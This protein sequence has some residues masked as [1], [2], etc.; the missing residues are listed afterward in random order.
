MPISNVTINNTFYEWLTTTNQLI[1]AVNDLNDGNVSLNFLGSN[2]IISNTGTF[3]SAISIAGVNVAPTLTAAFAQANTARSHANVSFSVGNS[4]FGHANVAYAQANTARDLGNTVFAATN[5]AFA[6]ANTGASVGSAYDQA[7]TARNS[8]NSALT[9][10]GVAFDQANTARIHA[11]SAF[12][13]ANSAYNTANNITVFPS[14]TR[15][16]FQQTSA[17]TGWTKIT[18]HNDKTLRVVS[19]TAS[20]GGS[21][22][23]ST[24]FASKTPT[25]SVTMNSVTLSE[26]NLPVVTPTV[27]YVTGVA[28]GASPGLL[29]INDGTSSGAT[30][31]NS[32]GSASPFTPTGSFSGNAM[33]FAVQYVDVILASKD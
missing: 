6:Q 24:V 19:G 23:F 11:N 14:G 27:N 28:S 12:S 9:L 29:F 18:T 4:A 25:G 33:D 1:V 10:G 21:T 26:A 31:I 7:N 3:N 5:A 32:F 16:L 8:A 15:L 22:A 2:T 20:N 13:A 30:S 17:P